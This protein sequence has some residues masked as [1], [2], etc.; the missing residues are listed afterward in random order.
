MAKSASYPIS[1][2]ITLFLT[3]ILYLGFL[4]VFLT[5]HFPDETILTMLLL[6][7]GPFWFLLMFIFAVE[8]YRRILTGRLRP[9]QSVW[10]MMLGSLMVN[11][12]GLLINPVGPGFFTKGVLFVFVSGIL[13]SALAGLL[14]NWLV[15]QNGSFRR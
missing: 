7:I 12:V 1:I 14:V 5:K 3:P 6:Y 11:L 2:P 8:F 4:K 9:Y 13:I 10:F 15:S